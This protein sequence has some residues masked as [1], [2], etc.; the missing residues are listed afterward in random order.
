MSHQNQ[1]KTRH[2]GDRWKDAVFIGAAVLL[3]ALAI[4]ATTSKNVGK[5]VEHSWSVQVVDPN[6]Q[7]EVTR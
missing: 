2:G 1:I 6:T 5:P 7:L 4:G 3:T